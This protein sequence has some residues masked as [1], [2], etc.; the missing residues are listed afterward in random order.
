MAFA[1]LISW[2]GTLR[3]SETHRVTVKGAAGGRRSSAAF[4]LAAYAPRS[5]SASHSSCSSPRSSLSLPG[6]HRRLS[7][8]P[9]CSHCPPLTYLTGASPHSL[10]PQKT[11]DGMILLSRIAPRGSSGVHPR[12]MNTR[13]LSPP[14]SSGPSSRSA[15]PSP[16]P[17]QTLFPPR[18][19]AR[20][21]HH[22]P[23]E[24]RRRCITS[25]CQFSFVVR[26]PDLNQLLYL[27]L[28]I[29]LRL[30]LSP[31][32]PCPRRCS[33]YSS[34]HETFRLLT[35]I[36]SSHTRESWPDATSD[37]GVD[38]ATSHA[39]AWDHPF[40]GLVEL[41][42]P[43]PRPYL[44]PCHDVSSPKLVR[45]SCIPSAQTGPVFLDPDGA[46]GVV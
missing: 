43:H 13:S 42:F 5:S 23:G 44:R 2:Y 4:W 34:G 10:R 46:T 1:G 32:H 45:P 8:P 31:P 26:P 20:R 7:P 14:A 36:Y 6:A 35:R 25:L 40:P 33:S 18:D 12:S 11:T 28:S 17:A 27:G 16:N 30:R 37:A 3:T 9:R 21:G 24:R 39:R 41:S 15:R 38:A 22:V 29:H 19:R